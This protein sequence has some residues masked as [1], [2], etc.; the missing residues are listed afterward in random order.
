[1]YPDVPTAAEQQPLLQPQPQR[2]FTKYLF[3]LSGRQLLQLLFVLF[4]VHL[5]AT[6]T[7]S[8]WLELLSIMLR[9]DILMILG[10]TMALAIVCVLVVAMCSGPGFFAFLPW[11]FIFSTACWYIMLRICMVHGLGVTCWLPSACKHMEQD[12]SLPDLDG[13]GNFF[14]SWTW[15]PLG[16]FAALAG[17]TWRPWWL[18]FWVLPQGVTGHGPLL[19]LPWWQWREV[20]VGS[21][22]VP[23]LILLVATGIGVGATRWWVAILSIVGSFLFSSVPFYLTTDPFAAFFSF[24]GQVCARFGHDAVDLKVPKMSIEE[25]ISLLIMIWG[26]T[27]LVVSS[28]S[29]RLEEWNARQRVEESL[30][31]ALEHPFRAELEQGFGSAA[32]DAAPPGLRSLSQ[33]FGRRPSTSGEALTTLAEK[34][35]AL[36][37]A[38]QATRGE[39]AILPSRLQLYIDRD[40]LL[41]ESLQ[42]LLQ[43]PASELLAP[44]MSV[45]FASELGADAGGLTRDWFDSVAKALVVGTDEVNGSS[46]LATQVDQTLVPRPV[47]QDHSKTSQEELK[48]KLEYK[49]LMAV[50]RFLA[51]AVIRERPL[52]LSFS[53]IACKHLLGI[54]VGMADVQQLDPEFYRGRVQTVLKEGGPAE[55]E[56]VLGEPLRFM[57]APTELWP[58]PQ[59]LKPGG[60][61]IVVTEENKAEYVELLCEA[62]LCNGMRREIRCLLQGFWDLLPLG[63]FRQC[64]VTPRELSLLISGVGSLDPKEWAKCSDG[65]GTQVHRWFWEVVEDLNQEQ[66]CMLLHFTTGSSR[67]PPGGFPDV[68]PTFTVQVAPGGGDERLPVAHTCMNQLVLQE[69]TSK[70]QLHNKLLMALST[71]GFELV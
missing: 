41:E 65:H 40:R 9:G 32:I 3:W 54:P 48:T 22:F 39:S 14:M 25:W 26:L 11:L 1:M 21:V 37:E 62:Y 61:L 15:F 31:F 23:S 63:L 50:G 53:L 68:R 36:Q 30:L 70:E 19:Q 42:A 28:A 13:I 51:L 7:I 45:H 67:L 18:V 29:L 44:S 16:L 55:L 17:I 24:L 35:K 43:K 4:I 34:R 5:I 69:Y 59:E 38:C 6:D 60:A 27:R 33:Q 52:P 58:Q 12:K 8:A 64:K 20:I 57:S 56:A 10:L 66:R 2:S 47:G 71:E 49:S 46:L